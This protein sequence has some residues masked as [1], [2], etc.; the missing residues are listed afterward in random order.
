MVVGLILWVDDVFFAAEKVDLVYLALPNHRGKTPACY[1]RGAPIR[2][3]LSLSARSMAD[4]G[5]T[6]RRF[7][8][9][10]TE[11]PCPVHARSEA[12]WATIQSSRPS[13]WIVANDDETAFVPTTAVIGEVEDIF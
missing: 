3:I 11:R 5:L 6:M 10:L 12:R 13:R 9:G 1:E 7:I 8:C 2:R 4:I